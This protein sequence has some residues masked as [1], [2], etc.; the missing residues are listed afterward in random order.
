M[1]KKHLKKSAF[2]HK[3]TRN[4]WGIEGI[5]LNIG[6]PYMTKSQLTLHS[7]VKG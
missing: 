7:M 4:K 5:Y 1:Q 3:K 2:F 6:K